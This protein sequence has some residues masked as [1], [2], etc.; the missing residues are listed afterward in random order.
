[1]NLARV[2]GSVW[3]TCKDDRLSGRRMLLLQPM[4]FS[5]E[6]RG[7]AVAALDTMDAGPTDV[8]VYTT[9]SEAAIPF[10]PGLTPTDATVVGIVERIDHA[11][12][13]YSA[14]QV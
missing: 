11:D 7:S 14:T 8:V 6:D 3:S 10:K 1:M 13:R 5:G 2:I 9:A 4:T 12:W